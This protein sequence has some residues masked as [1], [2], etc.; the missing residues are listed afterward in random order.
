MES[1]LIVRTPDGRFALSGIGAGTYSVVIAGPGFARKTIERVR[2]PED[3]DVDLGTIAVDRGR[4]VRGRVTDV[5]GGGVAGATVTIHDRDT[6]R[7][8]LTRS[9]N[10]NG[11]ATTDANGNFRITALAPPLYEHAQGR[12]IVATHPVH[13]VSIERLL[14]P[15]ATSIDLVL[16]KPGGIDGRLQGSDTGVFVQRVDDPSFYWSTS[17]DRNGDFH[18]DNLAPGAYRVRPNAVTAAQ[19]IANVVGGQRATVSLVVPSEKVELRVVARGC[20]ETIT[21]RTEDGLDE[22]ADRPCGTSFKDLPSGSYQICVDTK[23]SP[24]RVTAT[25]AIQTANL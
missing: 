20:K 19:A 1:P 23:C 3:G 4:T 10:G 15:D 13:G 21:L 25:P 9:L 12:R 24:I 5:N 2:V 8:A 22:L 16:A 17:P 6:P 7:D 11:V 18:F 14:A